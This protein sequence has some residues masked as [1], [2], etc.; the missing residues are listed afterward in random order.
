MRILQLID[1]LDAGGAERMAVNYANA[2]ADNVA[3]SAVVATRKEGLLKAVLNP[4]VGYFF[5]ARKSTIDITAILRL[6]KFV[7]ANK[8]QIVHCH[9][10]SFFTAVLL[11]ITYSG[12]KIIWHD[13]YG[14]SMYL[15]KRNT[16]PLKAASFFFEGI[17]TV[18]RQLLEWSASNLYCKNVI[19]LPNFVGRQDTSPVETIL[20]GEEGKRIVCLANLRPQKNHFLLIDVAVKLKQSHPDWT[21]HL[22]GQDF[23]DAYSQE[24][25]ERITIQGLDKNVFLYGTKPDIANILDQSD[26]CILT[27]RSEGLPL[28]FLEYGTFGKPVV[29]TN[30]GELPNIVRDR[31]NGRIVPS[32]NALLFYEAVTEIIANTHLREK[33]GSALAATIINNYSEQAI[34]VR[35][36]S[37]LKKI[38]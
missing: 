7:K 26:I 20:L 31:E 17:I 11:K 23:K 36:T 6:R 21:F 16:I 22:V 13:H 10:S 15:S 34:M 4:K 25:K 30:V 14:N 9:G 32:E 24:I 35:Y 8:I 28:A 33:M 27:S 18:N 29:V 3:F 2:L 1:S 5:A 37:W 12:I 38:I 19:Y